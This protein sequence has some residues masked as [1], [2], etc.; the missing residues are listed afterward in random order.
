MAKRILITVFTILSVIILS[1][2]VWHFFLSVYEVKIEYV[3]D[4]KEL[5][6][7]STIYINCIAVNS[8]GWHLVYRDTQSKLNIQEGH[9]LI[10]VHNSNEKNEF[11]LKTKT[12]PGNFVLRISSKLAFSPTTFAFTISDKNR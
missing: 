3:S 7:N 8:L 10:T 12:E 4:S 2:F 11:V 9:N 1:F 5:S 6:Y